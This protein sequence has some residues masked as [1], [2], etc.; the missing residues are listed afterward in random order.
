MSNAIESLLVR[1]DGTMD[2]LRKTLG[3]ADTAVGKTDKSIGSKLS[4]M[5]DR[6]A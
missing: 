1:I 4:K 6:F 5:Q 3:D 2:G